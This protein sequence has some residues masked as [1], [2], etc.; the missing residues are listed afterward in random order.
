[1]Q[2]LEITFYSLVAR[3]SDN[4]HLNKRLWQE[5]VEKYSSAKR[6]YHNLAHIQNMIAELEEVKTEIREFDILLFS[7]FYHDVIYDASSN[8]NEEKSVQF[9][10]ERMIKISFVPADVSTIEAQILATKKHQRTSSSDTNFL[11]DADLS[12]LGKSWE[13][14]QEYSKQ[15]RKEY[16]HYPDFLY[17]PG[18]K[19]V[20]QHFLESDELFT[21]AFFKNKY[22][23]Q[24]RSNL[25][26]EIET[27]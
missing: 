19:K 4:V 21:T 6:Y 25:T 20:L 3:Y 22:E 14:Y 24:A 15:I 9:A 27:L 5:I 26:R 11:L 10:K 23:N 13:T 17:R 18:R 7:V 2:E 16:A 1:M 12:I 8:S